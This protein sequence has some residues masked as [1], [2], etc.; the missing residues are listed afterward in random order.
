MAGQLGY[1]VMNQQFSSEYN[2]WSYSSSLGVDSDNITNPQELTCDEGQWNNDIVTQMAQETSNR[3]ISKP[4]SR[5]KAKSSVCSEDGISWSSTPPGSPYNA[6][7]GSSGVY[8]P[9][10]PRDQFQTSGQYFRA[11][12][13][14]DR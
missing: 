14:Y 8:S 6:S 13:E 1:F 12:V 3:K 5:E 4:Q 10:P 2:T 9:P 7:P 11:C